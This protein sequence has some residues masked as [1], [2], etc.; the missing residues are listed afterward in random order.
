MVSGCGQSYVIAP[1]VIGSFLSFF[2]A[3]PGLPLLGLVDVCVGAF[4]RGS[5]SLVHPGYLY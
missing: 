3:F 5:G 2:E 4:L 1:G